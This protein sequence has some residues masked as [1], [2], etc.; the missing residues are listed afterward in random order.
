MNLIEYPDR[1]AWAKGLAQALIGRL[2][3]ELQTSEYASFS[4]PGGTTPGP[5]FDV[6]S[7]AKLEWDRVHILLNDERRVPAEHERSNERLIRQRLLVSN[8]A[9]A[10]YISIRDTDGI[11]PDISAVLP[12]SV[13]LLGM[14]AD[15]HT[16]SLFPGSQ[17]LADALASDAPP[18][19]AV[20]ASDGLEPR[21]TMTGPVL[22][23]AKDVHLLI[24]GQEKRAA[25]EKAVNLPPKEAPIATVLP[26]ATV[27][28]AD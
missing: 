7:A 6:L 13:L 4:V 15:M 16:A 3:T 22:S 9:A 24:L 11:C 8:A 14:G 20:E 23:A 25:L 2:K 18:L 26:K 1:E 19:M 28:W 17:D 10:N 5:V 12:I 21:I 27:H